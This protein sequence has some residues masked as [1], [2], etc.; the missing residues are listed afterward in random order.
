[1]KSCYGWTASG[2]TDV[3][4]PL[5]SDDDEEEQQQQQ[6]ES[7]SGAAKE[8]G[9][10][11]GPQSRSRCGTVGSSI[12]CCSETAV[13]GQIVPERAEGQEL[14]TLEQHH[15]HQQTK[16]A[17]AAEVL[18]SFP[19]QQTGPGV[20][21]VDVGIGFGDGGGGGGGSARLSEESVVRVSELPD[22]CAICLGQYVA[23]EEVHVLPCL[24]IFHAQV[25]MCAMFCLLVCV[26]V[27]SHLFLTPIYTHSSVYC[28]RPY[29]S[30]L[31]GWLVTPFFNVS[32][33]CIKIVKHTITGQEQAAS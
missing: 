5:G 19:G 26:C 28:M 18:P 16:N 33:S 8:E 22:V 32:F 3:N 25:K 9:G 27:G 21:G 31:V 10:Q 2:Q 30:G 29:L 23:G 7:S 17:A 14:L 15:H 12:D 24:H 13:V 11:E 20:S 1:M 4:L 6:E